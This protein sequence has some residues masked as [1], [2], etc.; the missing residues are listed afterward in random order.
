MVRNVLC[1][2]RVRSQHRRAEWPARDFQTREWAKARPVQ[3]G[4]RTGSKHEVGRTE[5][6]SLGTTVSKQGSD[7][8]EAVLLQESS[9][10]NVRWLTAERATW[11]LYHRAPPHPHQTWLCSRSAPLL[12]S[13]LPQSAL[14]TRVVTH[15]QEH[16]TGRVTVRRQPDGGG[17]GAQSSFLAHQQ[18]SQEVLQSLSFSTQHSLCTSHVVGSQQQGKREDFTSAFKCFRPKVI[19]VISAQ[20]HCL[21][22]DTGGL[23]RDWVMTLFTWVRK[24]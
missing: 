22:Q 2:P 12:S 14:T 20:F 16:H 10:Q 1:V 13:P 3:H 5:A 23:E 24:N 17:G 7:G 9:W 19:C 11:L 8:T 6:Y 18:G 4:Q 15:R 21:Q